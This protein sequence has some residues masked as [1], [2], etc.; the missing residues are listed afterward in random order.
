[1]IC[2]ENLVKRFG[3]FAAL[4]DITL[5]ISP[6]SIYGLVGSNGAGKSTLMRC[7]AGIYEPEQGQLLID[8]KPVFENLRS[9]GEITAPVF[10]YI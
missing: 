9:R 8:E 7:I 5:E 4:D 10:E 3:S 1:M 2:V 6:G